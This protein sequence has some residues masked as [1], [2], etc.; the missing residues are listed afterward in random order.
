MVHGK[1]FH[2]HS[3][4]A[5]VDREDVPAGPAVA[6]IRVLLLRLERVVGLQRPGFPVALLLFAPDTIR[7]SNL[8]LF[9]PSLWVGLVMYPN[10]H[11]SDYRLRDVL[12]LTIIRAGPTRWRSGLRRGRTL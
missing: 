12:P 5:A 2:G 3:R 10:W 4:A 1:H 9:G 8:L 11:L 7:L 6:H